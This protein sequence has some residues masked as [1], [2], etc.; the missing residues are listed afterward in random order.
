LGLDELLVLNA[1]MSDR[2][3]EASEAATLMQQGPVPAKALLE[4]M[5]EQ[6][7]VEGTGERPR[8]YHLSASIYRRLASPEGYVR[9]HGIDRLRWEGLVMEWAVSH[10][11]V[12]RSDVITLLQVTPDQAYK[13]LERMCTKGKLVRQGRGRRGS[14][15]VPGP[16]AEE[17]V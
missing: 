13:L 9:T 7:M 14:F 11:R 5:V 12:A 1:L 10:S 6:G 17:G 16:S 8:V 2:R 15:Y 4:R 3:L